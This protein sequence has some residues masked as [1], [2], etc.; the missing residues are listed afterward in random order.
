MGFLSKGFPSTCFCLLFVVVCAVEPE[1]RRGGMQAPRHG[2]NQHDGHDMFPLVVGA[3]LWP[4]TGGACPDQHS[5]ASQYQ[6]L[7]VPSTDD[8]AFGARARRRQGGRRGRSNDDGA[9]IVFSGSRFSETG[10][11]VGQEVDPRGCTVCSETTCRALF[12]CADCNKCADVKG[13]RRACFIVE[14][15][16][17]G[18]CAR[19]SGR[20]SDE[21]GRMSRS[22]APGDRKYCFFEPVYIHRYLPPLPPE[23]RC[24]SAASAY[25]RRFSLVQCMAS[26]PP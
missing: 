2:E 8:D 6:R 16:V 9:T 5:M 26:T 20:F 22:F 11:C 1:N 15:R 13:F 3:Y 10:R 7:P 12:A 4:W 19:V 23:L 25:A 14:H 21:D 17:S 24:I 18:S